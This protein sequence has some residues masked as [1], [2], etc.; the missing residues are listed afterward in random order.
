MAAP[1]SAYKDRQFLAVI[2]D[3]VRFTCALSGRI[4]VN[5]QQDSVTGLLLAGI[6]VRIAPSRTRVEKLM[7]T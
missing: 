7:A 2:G 4:N 1:A 3:E 5:L 6:G